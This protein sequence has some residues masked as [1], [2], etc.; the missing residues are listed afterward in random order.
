VLTSLQ[1]ADRWMRWAVWGASVQWR[2]MSGAV[3]LVC[4]GRI[5]EEQNCVCSGSWRFGLGSCCDSREVGACVLMAG[6]SGQI[7]FFCSL[8][9][10]RLG[11]G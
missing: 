2:V 10:K 1:E 7:G 5:E 3:N 6:L 4:D 11:V 9:N 8:L